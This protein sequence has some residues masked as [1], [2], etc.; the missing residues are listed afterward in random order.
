MGEAM[1]ASCFFAGV[2]SIF[3][4]EQL[5]TTDNPNHTDDQELFSKLGINQ[6]Q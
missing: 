5:L 2:N 1:Q 6:A 4:G 3:Y